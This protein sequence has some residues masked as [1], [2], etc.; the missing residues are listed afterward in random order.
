MRFTK[1]GIIL[2]SDYL[3]NGYVH[4]K[5]H[6]YDKSDGRT[7]TK[8]NTEWTQK[9]RIFLYDFLKERDIVPL[10]EKED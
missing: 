7:G 8:E 4:S 2:Y 10:I 1:E 3:G 6:K 9:G 5:T